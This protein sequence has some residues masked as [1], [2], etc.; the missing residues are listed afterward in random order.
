MPLSGID[1]SVKQAILQ[2]NTFDNIDLVSSV[3]TLRSRRGSHVTGA[4]GASFFG[5]AVPGTAG[6]DNAAVVHNAGSRR[7]SRVQ[8]SDL[9]AQTLDLPGS[10]NG[11]PGGSS[12]V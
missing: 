9:P 2:R 3:T 5:S 1:E 8:F 10:S 11:M 6:S 4:N 7:Q 12:P